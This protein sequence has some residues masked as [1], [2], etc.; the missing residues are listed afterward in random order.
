MS[1]INN[2]KNEIARH[3]KSFTGKYPLYYNY[4]DIVHI[5][6]KYG[7]IDP[8]KN[9]RLRILEK[10]LERLK[11][12]KRSY[13]NILRWEKSYFFIFMLGFFINAILMTIVG[14][15]SIKTFNQN[16]L[17]ITM[18]TSTTSLISGWVAFY[19]RPKVNEKTFAKYL[20]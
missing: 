18:I 4:S 3:V 7:Y 16:R 10:R 15:L 13:D 5:Y 19:L 6:K 14:L 17:N 20:K 9:S 8:Q 2:L 1:L 11:E 12:L